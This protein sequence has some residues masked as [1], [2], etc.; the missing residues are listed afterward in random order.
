MDLVTIHN[1]TLERNMQYRY[2][3]A[4][5]AD[6]TD[7]AFRRI[8][9][10]YGKPDMMW[11]EFVSADGL[12]HTREVVHLPDADN[13]LMRALVYDESERP[14]IAQVFTAR[15]EMA[16]Y[17]ATLVRSLGFDGID[18]NMGCPD[19]A[20]LKQGAGAALIRNPPLA[21]ELIRALKRGAGTMPVLVKTRIGTT[22]NELAT[23]LP[24][25]LAEAPALITIHARTQKELSKVPARWECVREAVS[26]RDARGAPVCIFGNGDVESIV[27]ARELVKASGAD[28]VMLGRAIF[29]NPWL[30]SGRTMEPTTHERI[31]ALIEHLTLW[32]E[33][34]GHKSFAVMKKHVHAYLQGFAGAR[35]LRLEVTHAT[36][37]HE[38]QTM[39]E[40]YLAM[41]T[42]HA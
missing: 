8:I 39:L 42:D 5:M 36:S 35:D 10:R 13:P 28:G 11:T 40:A 24:E 22:T 17:A 18:I 38:A 14:I 32:D 19:R 6:V 4:P 3:L 23:W 27:H 29:G 7:P 12:Y 21:R 26:I 25:L 37:A 33:L 2:V 41:H 34:M 1:M 30:F 16:E 9:A 15:P 20:V 31:H